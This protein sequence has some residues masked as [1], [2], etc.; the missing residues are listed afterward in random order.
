[1]GDSVVVVNRLRHQLKKS[2][3]IDFAARERERMRA[4]SDLAHTEETLRAARADEANEVIYMTERFSW[5]DRLEAHRR[6]QEDFLTVRSHAAEAQREVLKRA[7]QEARATELVLER[8]MAEEDM[9]NRR[10]EARALDALAI[11]RW[12]SR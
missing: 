3:R 2:A 12:R 10:R 5:L 1:M 6:V 9:E 8:S 4:E 7:S 11:T